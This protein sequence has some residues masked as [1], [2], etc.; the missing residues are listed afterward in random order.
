MDA[1][2]E[3][4]TLDKIYEEIVALR[5]QVE[6]LEMRMLPTEELDPEELAELRLLIEESKTDSIPWS[7]LKDRVEELIK[8]MFSKFVSTEN[9]GKPV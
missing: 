8:W 7:E 9:Q 1:L 4:V 2:T 3:I 6:F 5:R